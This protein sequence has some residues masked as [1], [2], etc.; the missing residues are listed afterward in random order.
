MS[1]ATFGRKG[2]AQD[3]DLVAR[4]AAFLAEER[5]R[6]QSANADRREVDD[7][8]PRAPLAERRYAP[9]KTAG[10]AYLLWFFLGGVSAHRFYL[11]FHAS[12]I[13]QLIMTPTAYAMMIAKSPAGVVL[14]VVA[15][16]WILVDAAFI[17][18]MVNKANAR[19]RGDAVASVFA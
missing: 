17:P 8:L 18:G 12:A 14:L 1:G 13:V 15:G 2:A 6:A 3:A 7:D 19:G 10:V 11:G 5:A 9:E 4:R 16:I